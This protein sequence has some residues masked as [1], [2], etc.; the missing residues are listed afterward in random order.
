MLVCIYQRVA[1]M[2]KQSGSR[3]LL[4]DLEELFRGNQ[5]ENVNMNTQT[6]LVISHKTR[7]YEVKPSALSL[8]LI[9]NTHT[10]L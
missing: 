10:L 7:N 6:L 3:N 9:F 8:S 4:T 1:D 5:G 2:A